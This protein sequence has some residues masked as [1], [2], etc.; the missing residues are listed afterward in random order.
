VPN[1]MPRKADVALNAPPMTAV[2]TPRACLE[3]HPNVTA[4]HRCS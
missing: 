2:V 4:N 3:V 1:T